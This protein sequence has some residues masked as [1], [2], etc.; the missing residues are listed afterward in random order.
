V[1]SNKA[2]KDLPEDKED[3]EDG[4]PVIDENLFMSYLDDYDYDDDE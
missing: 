3:N 1:T 4:F 2:K